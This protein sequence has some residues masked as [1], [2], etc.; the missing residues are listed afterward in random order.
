[1]FKRK[2]AVKKQL[3]GAQ[4]YK[5]WSDYA[6]G[7]MVIGTFV[8]VHTCQYDKEN[9]KIKVEDCFFKDGSG[10]DLIGKTLVLNNCGSLAK[11]MEDVNE[12]DLIQVEYLGKSVLEKGL[13]AGKEAHSVAVAIVEEEESEESDEGL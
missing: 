5:K 13:Y 12:K 11:A 4:T 3:N 6:T 8:G 9:Y 2:F 10:E 7:D 1:M